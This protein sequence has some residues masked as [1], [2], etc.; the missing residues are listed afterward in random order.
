M[1]TLLSSALISGSLPAV[2]QIVIHYVQRYEGNNK[3]SIKHNISSKRTENIVMWD[4]NRIEF[5]SAAHDKNSKC[6]TFQTKNCGLPYP[7]LT[8]HIH[9]LF[10]RICTGWFV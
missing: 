1:T 3:E 10:S 6:H 8:S 2:A 4:D 7:V 5:S 9:V